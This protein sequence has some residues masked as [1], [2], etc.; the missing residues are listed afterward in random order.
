MSIQFQDYYATLGVDK[1]A[2]QDA[3]KKAFRNLA[4]R[5]HPDHVEAAQREQAEKKFKE[6]NEAYEVLKDPEKRRKYDRL[7]AN[8]QQTES[9]SFNAYHTRGY[10]AGGN[11]FGT[12]FDGSQGGFEFHFG[13]TGFSDFFEQFFG[14][15]TA[16]AFSEMRGRSAANAK[17]Q[18]VEAEILVTLEE[19]LKGAKRTIS[20]RRTDSRTGQQGLQTYNVTIPVGVEEGQRIRLRGQG[21]HGNG[22]GYSGDLLLRVK[23]AQHPLLKARKHTLYY[24]LEI[25]PWE[26]VLGATIV[27]E[28]LDGHVNLKIQPGTQNGQHL[29]LRGLGLPDKTGKRGDLEVVIAVTM[30]KVC[31]EEERKHWESL[32]RISPFNPRRDY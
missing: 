22:D 17:G 18:D 26:A 10:R 13:G 21:K 5:F 2:S 15:H 9:G 30:P 20:L 23:Y 28:A 7:G 14:S 6:I 32:A 29:R 25:A 31:G 11:P 3:V 19:V 12:D 24:D 8:W 16:G 1:K 27:I 4:R